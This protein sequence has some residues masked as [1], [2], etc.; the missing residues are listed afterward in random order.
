MPISFDDLPEIFVSST[1]ISALVNQ[2]VKSGKLKKIGSR[3]YTKNLDS[4][5][6]S[7]VRKNWYFLLK[8][9]YP[10][11]LIADRTAIENQP[12]SDGSVFIVSSKKRD[13]ALPG[14]T[15]RP[16]QGV[17]ALETDKP[18]LGNVHLSSTARAYLEN[19][20]ISRSRDGNVPRTLSHKEIEER[21]DRILRQAGETGLNAIRDEA[22][23]LAPLLD[24]ENE[25][26]EL[27]EVI[28]SLL[29]TRDA[30]MQ[31]AI[32]KAR[33][34]GLPYD[35]VRLERFI[36]LFEELKSTAPIQRRDREKTNSA[37]NNL[38]FFEAYFSNFIEGT[39]FEIDEAIDIIFNGRIPN[40]RPEDAHDILGTFRIVSDYSEMSIL[41][42]THDDFLQL[43]KARHAIFMELRPEKHPGVFKI[44]N[45]QAGSSLFVS[46][47]LV[48]G[49]LEKGFKIY[50]SLDVP[51]YRAIFMMFLISEV[52]PFTDGNGR[53]AR[54]MM[55]AELVAADEEKIIIPTIYRS[56][57]LSS[58]KALTHNGLTAPLIRTLDF[59]QKYTRSINWESFDEAR[60]QLNFTNAFMDPSEADEAGIRLK[61]YQEE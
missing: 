4:T 53:A 41:P 17:G 30:L 43:L 50:Q 58:L 16:R 56:N 32:G 10:D 47:D 19:M 11:A 22:R 44:K 31:S 39:E 15:F 54:I 45:N 49:S 57:Y 55:N 18:F 29:G 42:K 6:E 46:P 14:I 40:D 34:G 52:H 3:L 26:K 60:R 24:A 59:A 21:L 13:T 8:D 33:K 5:P 61:L 7:V 23:K 25:F 2:A 35:P 37:R 48:E 51:L 27:D 1:K 12:S 38:S 20:R 9:Y 28:G 36:Q